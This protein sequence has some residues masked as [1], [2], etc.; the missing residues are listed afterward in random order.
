MSLKINKTNIFFSVAVFIC[1]SFGIWKTVELG[2]SR[3]KTMLLEAELKVSAYQWINQLHFYSLIYS[4]YFHK[5]ASVQ[6]LIGDKT[7]V[8]IYRFAKNTCGVCI[9]EDLSE[10]EL[11]QQE[12]GREKVLLL[13]A[14]PNSRESRIEMSNI[15]NKFNYLNMTLDSFFMPIQPCGSPQRYFALI[16]SNRNLTMVFFPQ[17]GETDLTQLYFS[18]IKKLL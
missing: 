17:K 1:F 6:E 2:N 4:D 18:H 13:P 15:F 14:Y 9:R 5:G 16:D 10:I 3:S 11:L 12:I 7:P 8:L